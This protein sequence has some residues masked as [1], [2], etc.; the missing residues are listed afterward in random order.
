M[1]IL[2]RYDGRTPIYAFFRNI[3]SII[4]SV[5]TE[6]MD[7]GRSK[8]SGARSHIQ[9]TLV[10]LKSAMCD[11]QIGKLNRSE[12]ITPDIT[13]LTKIR[14]LQVPGRE[15]RWGSKDCGIETP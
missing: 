5:F 12:P 10:G 7:E 13:I 9:D 3:K 6:E 1:W 14:S 15:E 8:F 11:D 2:L 4:S